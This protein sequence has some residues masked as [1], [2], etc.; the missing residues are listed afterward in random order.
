M[1]DQ[2]DYKQTLNL[3]QTDF[4]MRASLPQREPKMLEQWSKLDLYAHIRRA[5]A[6]RPRYLL[7]DGPPYA[8]GKIHIGHAVNKTLKDII[9]RARTLAGFDA[10]YVPGW[11]CHGLPIELQV[12]KKHGRAGGKLDAVAFRKACRAYAEKQVDDQRQDFIRL[13]VVGDWYK[14]YLTM[15][16]SYEAQQLRLLA[17]IIDRGHL[18]KGYKPVH[19][20]MDCRSALAEAEVEYDN[21]TS[22]AIDV[23]FA[24][25]DSA[26]F[27]T[28]IGVTD[29]GA[30]TL[31]IWTTT[32]WTLPANQAVTV[33]PE[34][35]YVLLDIDIDGQRERL[36]TVPELSDA[37]LARAGATLVAQVASFKGQVLE[38][39]QLK[40][41]FLDRVVPVITGDHVTVEAGTGLVH[42]AP[43]HG[44]DDFIVGK[45]F[46]LPLENPVG[47]NGCFKDDT[48]F[49]AG[50]HVLKA[51]DHVVEVLREHNALLHHE[52]YQHQYPHCWR[53]KSPV[54]FRATPQWFISMDKAHLRR[55]A[56]TAIGNVQWLPDWGEQRI[57]GMVE[58]R[59]DWCI[60]RQR[61]WG[62]PIAVFVHKDTDELHPRSSE[63]LGQVADRVAEGGI[64]AWQS[65]EPADL[66]GDEASDYRKVTDTMDVW[67]DSGSAHF[68]TPEGNAAL[69]APADLYLE[70]SDQHRGWFQSSLLTSVAMNGEAPYK[71]VLTH[72]FTVD[73]HGKKMSKSV[74]N[75]IAPQKIFSTLGADILRLWIAASDY[76]NEM[77]VSEEILKRMADSYRRMR[78]TARFLL[79]N[80]D[81][82]DPSTD[83]IDAADML[84]IDRWA[85]A[86]TNALQDDIV[87][88][89]ETFEFH[90]IYQRLHNF[91]VVDMGG[92]YLDV[93]KDRLY[94]TG[95][96]S[97]TR[98]SAQ[99]V[100]WHIA[101]AMVRWLAPIMPFTA[102][103]IWQQLPGERDATVMT[104]QW[105]TLPANVVDEGIDWDALIEVR[106]A[107]S[108]E[109][110][111]LRAAKAVG[112]PLEAR[113]T[114]YAGDALTQ[115]LGALG[116]ELRFFL[117]TSS[118]DV[119]P[120]SERGQSAVAAEEGL[121]GRLW[122]ETAA[123]TDPKCQRC[124]H[125]RDDIGGDTDHPTLCVR[126]VDNIAGD[127][128]ARAFV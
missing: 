52:A 77:S 97:R 56:M 81:G 24:A 121:A 72:G 12:E 83:A 104:S 115:V 69:A 30:V 78:N 20:C 4:P 103:E 89:Y 47:D 113:V 7:L 124:W 117:I 101:E 118:A 74:G 98:R 26:D 40:H 16:P 35:D 60:S 76:R 2:T 57:Q 8:N 82:F 58:G 44:V 1:A 90:R 109:L 29:E 37:L 5:C 38:G 123:S 14:P 128:E 94:T 122:V 28:R 22:P 80:L 92:L 86:R 110:E 114:L 34:F 45:R 100:M 48:E 75:T 18:Y 65:I 125:R 66:L 50:E 79:G 25:V 36:V 49:F 51:N 10:P 105:H 127:G 31:P 21:K 67:F 13:G 106:T 85:V 15:Q 6:G 39:L 99:T 96:N 23:R 73:E 119:K 87:K 19:W 95:A 54:I 59:P 17:R 11:D 55:D 88:A 3:P 84:A 102:E 93:L 33:H 64:D 108:R 27:Y 61:I 126:C 116:D 43:G 9:V 68:C 120:A 53:H 32:P 41:P 91:C 42:T 112:S 111:A 46:N 63:L 70:G 71:A 62:V 107:V